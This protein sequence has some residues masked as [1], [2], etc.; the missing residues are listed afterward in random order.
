MAVFLVT[1]ALL[2]NVT[3]SLLVVFTVA[4]IEIDVIGI[5]YLWGINLNAVSTVN[6]VMAIGISVEFCVHIAHSFMLNHGTRVERARAALTKMG[7]SVF[8]GITL[9]KFVGVVVLAFS[10][11]EIFRVYYF[12]MFFSIVILGA[13]H[14]LMFFPALL[15]IVGPR[16]HT[17]SCAIY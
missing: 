17:K 6:L 9:T 10:T 4:M 14:G 2:G 13:L 8:K 7:A 5:M 15:S 16:P 12:R 3:M 1:L 11:S